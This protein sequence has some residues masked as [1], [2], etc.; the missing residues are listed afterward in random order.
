MHFV[1]RRKQRLDVL[2]KKE[3]R[4][5][6]RAVNNR[7]SPIVRQ[8]GDFVRLG[9]ARRVERGRVGQT[10][11]VASLQ[12]ADA[13][14]PEAAQR[15]RRARAQ[16]LRS[17][18]AAA[19]RKIGAQ[20][21]PLHGA[22]RQNLTRSGGER[23]M[24]DDVHAVQRR[25][26]A[27]AAQREDAIGIEAQ[28]RAPRRHLQCDSGLYIANDPVGQPKAQTRPSGRSAARQPTTGQA[29]R[30]I[31]AG[32]IARRGSARRA[33]AAGKRIALSRFVATSPRRNASPPAM[34]LR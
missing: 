34:A 14:T 8:H 18:E 20:P 24:V 3:V 9:G 31:P 29:A 21:R 10:Q 16:I 13:M 7:Q 19:H 1:A 28:R 12:R 32:W 4:R 26:H 15:E 30:A 25:F 27:R 33:S 22:G 6:V 2:L 11:N 17:V 23:R 5:A